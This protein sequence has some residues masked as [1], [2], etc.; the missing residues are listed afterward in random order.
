MK[1]MSRLNRTLHKPNSRSVC[2]DTERMGISVRP[3]LPEQGASIAR[4]AWQVRG[5]DEYGMI[6]LGAGRTPP[7]PTYLALGIEELISKPH[8]P[9]MNCFCERAIGSIRR[10]CTDHIIAFSQAQFLRVLKRYC[11]YYNF[12]RTHIGLGKDAL[13]PRAAQA[14]GKVVPVKLVGGLHTCYRRVAR[15]TML[16]ALF[17]L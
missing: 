15:L 2:G 16:V 8:S 6:S 14:E 12:W 9:W 1:R 5:K 10:E 3:P 17:H 11:V 7:C 13:I 4:E